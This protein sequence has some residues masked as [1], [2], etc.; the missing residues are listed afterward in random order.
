VKSNPPVKAILE[1]AGSSTSLSALRLAARKSRLFVGF[2][3]V[4][5]RITCKTRDTLSLAGGAWIFLSQIFV[6]NDMY[7]AT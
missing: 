3:D 5:C 1:P 6:A 7:L 2:R 4:G